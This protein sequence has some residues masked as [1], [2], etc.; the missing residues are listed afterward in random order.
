[1]AADAP[2]HALEAFEY[3]LDAIVGPW[4]G[5]SAREVSTAAFGDEDAAIWVPLP[6]AGA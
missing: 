1:V 4:V 2:S 5:A 3:S 6:T